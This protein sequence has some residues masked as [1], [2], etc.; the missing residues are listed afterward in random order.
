MKQSFTLIFSM[1]TFLML[2]AQTVP[3]TQQ[4]LITKVTADWCPNC[5]TWG[6]SF[7]EDLIADNDDD[8]LMLAAH[9]S[10]GLSNP[11]GQA[12]SDN[13]NSVGQP[14]FFLNNVDKNV[15]SSSVA[16]KRIEIQNEVA[17][18]AG[19]S[20]IAS[21]AVDVYEDGTFNV[22]TQF[23]EEA[24]GEFY[25]AVY[26]VEEGVSHNQ[27]PI[28]VT[29]HHDLVRTAITPT[30]FGDLMA[31]GE[32]MSG[33]II[34]STYNYILN[35]TWDIN[36]LEFVTIVWKK[37]GNTYQFVNGTST[38]TIL[39]VATPVEDLSSEIGI[40]I[41]PTLIEDGAAVQLN[42]D[43]HRN[44]HIDIT[45]ILGQSVALIHQGELSQ[46]NH[47]IPF[48]RENLDSGVYFIRIVS[49]GKISS[50]KVVLR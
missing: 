4:S 10:G 15:S 14:R 19:Q 38:T 44:I 42:I 50:Q 21:A 16:T 20:P 34:D 36:A 30:S 29:D 9:Y 13:F 6:W 22:R 23:F 11:I 12:L 33:E 3:Q 28:G 25:T 37:E 31:M 49:E 27:Q 7:Y 32:I 18:N 24:S 45:N 2:S 41:R 35:P 40:Q 39:E 46:G 5:G 17:A 48:R 1:F 26:I 43:R 47:N 8:A